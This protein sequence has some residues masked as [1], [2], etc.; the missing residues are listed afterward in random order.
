MNANLAYD[1]DAIIEPLITA[2]ATVTSLALFE[3]YEPLVANDAEF[4]TSVAEDYD[5]L[6][7]VPG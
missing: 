1:Y 3:Q 5:N 2:G 7:L 6:Y 4:D